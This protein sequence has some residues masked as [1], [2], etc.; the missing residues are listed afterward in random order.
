MR[1]EHETK[2][3]AINVVE[4]YLDSLKE[5]EHWMVAV[6]RLD[7]GNIKMD[8]TCFQYPFD[9]FEES[10]FLLEENLKEEKVSKGVEDFSLTLAPLPVAD[11]FKT[12]YEAAREAMGPVLKITKMNEAPEIVEGENKT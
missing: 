3:E 8:R 6:F 7:R 12:V 5:S 1:T 2:R 11:E 10:T 4:G 9:R